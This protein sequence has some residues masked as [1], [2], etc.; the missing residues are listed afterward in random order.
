MI[1]R[2][3]DRITADDF[4]D[5]MPSRKGVRI[6]SNVF[7]RRVFLFDE[8]SPRAILVIAEDTECFTP[9]LS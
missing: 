9:Q 6:L 3:D 7:P 1:T 4:R 2:L 8:Q 5:R